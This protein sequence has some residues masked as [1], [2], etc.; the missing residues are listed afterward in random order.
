MEVIKITEDLNAYTHLEYFREQAIEHT[1]P[2]LLP[3]TK[4][5][6]ALFENALRFADEAAG[7]PVLLS[8]FVLILVSGVEELSSLPTTRLELYQMATS[9]AFYGGSS[10][11]YLRHSKLTGQLFPQL[12]SRARARAVKRMANRAR[13][14]S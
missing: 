3:S 9:S 11:H 14:R 6:N 7:V 4:E 10:G 13:R 1:P 5:L 12:M 8:M 2:S